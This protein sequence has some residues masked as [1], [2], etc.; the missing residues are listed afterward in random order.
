MAYNSSKG[1][2]DVQHI[3]ASSEIFSRSALTSEG[4]LN[5]SGSTALGDNKADVI[6]I[7]GQLTGSQGAYFADRVGVGVATPD[8]ALEVA[9]NV[10]LSTE[11]TTPSTPAAADGGV[12]YVK[13][14]GNLYWLSD[15][16][17]EV[18]LSSG[19]GISFNGSTANGVV[20]YGGATQADVEANM[21]FNGSQL[22]VTG[23]MSASSAVK[24]SNIVAGG[25][26]VISEGRLIQNVLGATIGGPITTT[27]ALSGSSGFHS[28]G[29]IT[30]EGTL[31]ATGSVVASQFDVGATNVISS[32]RLIQNVLGATIGGPLTATG[33]MSGSS[34]LEA[35]GATILGST[36]NV[37]G[38]VTLA[39]P[40][41]GSIAGPG[42]YLG[43]TPTGVVVLAEASG[44]GI[45]FN[46]STAN[47]V[48]TY[49]GATQADVEANLT[50]DG[51][52]LTATNSSNTAI[53]AITIDRN[54]TGT[55][56]IGNYTTDPQ[57]LLVDYD[58]T[59]IV[60]SGQTAIH[61]AISI[62]YNQDSPTM[63][64][65]IE[66]TG[67]DIRMTGGTS[68]TQ[69]MKGLAMTLA[70]AST[71]TGIDITAPNDST[72]FIA[73]SSDALLDQFKIS[74][75][76]GGATTLSTN[77]ADATAAHLTFSVD[78][79]IVL[80]PAGSNVTVDG[81]LSG[82]G[83]LEMVGATVL[84][85]TLAVSGTVSVAAKIEHAG[86]TDTYIDFTDDDINFQ[87][88]GVNFLDLTQDTQ[89]E[90][91][92]NEAG[93]DIDFRVET[94][95]ESHML[96]IE[97][98]SNRM[99]IG[100]NTG[101]PGATLEVKNNATAGAF[102]VP[103][104]RLNSNDT[105]QQCLDINAANID[106][107]V[108]DI[109]A[110]AVT[111]AKVLNIGADG[112]TTGNAFRVDDNSA[113]TGTRNT[114]L[115]I[116]NN[117]AAIAATALAVQSD[118]GVTGVKI[119]KNYS[120]TAEASV[121]GLDIDFDKTAATTSDN[122]MYGIQLDMD[123]TTAT[124]GTNYMYGLHVTPTLTHA[125]D[126]GSSFV[127]GAWINAQGGTNGTGYVQGARIEAGG[128]DLNFGLQLDVEDGGVDLRIES[129][130][131]NGDYFQ[132]QTTTHGA[133][134]ITTVD[135]NATA[136]D[137]TFNVD[138]DITLDPV[139][140]TVV[141]D[142]VLSGSSALKGSN[143][144]AGGAN[145]ISDGRLIQ[146]VLGATIGG[147]LTT[148]GDLSGSGL[149]TIVGGIVN[150]GN[151]DVS[152][153]A[154]L[155]NAASD[156]T[157]ATGRLTGSQGAYFAGRVGI[158]QNAPAY[159]LDL[160]GSLHLNGNLG[161]PIAPLA[162]EG[163]VLF[164][165]GSGTL[166]WAS[167]EQMSRDISNQVFHKPQGCS[168]SWVDVD[169]VQFTPTGLDGNGR[170]SL[171][172]DTTKHMMEYT[173]TGSIEADIT[174]SGFNGLDTGTEAANTGYYIYIICKDD[175][176]LP[177][178]LFSTNNINPTMPSGYTYRSQPIWFVS[179]DGSAEIRGFNQRGCDGTFYYDNFQNAIDNGQQLQSSGWAA[180]DMSE[181]VPSASDAL[182]LMRIS[183]DVSAGTT[184][185]RLTTDNGTAPAS[186]IGTYFVGRLSSNGDV[187]TTTWFDWALS[188]A[189]SGL[190]YCWVN[191]P[192]SADQGLRIDVG[193]FK[194]W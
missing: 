61:D 133:T 40:A 5:I 49:G 152:G 89:N 79:N 24:G 125:A 174:D 158:S 168:F 108:V 20:T 60:A 181:F 180:V 64:G 137:L 103:L 86:D 41:S 54:Y 8:S 15:D 153:S 132:I 43:V 130:A 48:V 117:A 104:L 116:Q 139:G 55:T 78:G 185:C 129:S 21:T 124:N 45:S 23:I 28:A 172:K 88:G 162:T 22:S 30:A 29:N 166:Y 53:P 47:G 83:T 186:G 183:G 145:V 68:G 18:S 147:P 136:A 76:A 37:S 42:S 169:T 91:T 93:A 62:N 114:A 191:D 74:V 95:D 135:D 16:V 98:S 101:S 9:G 170:V 4:N 131:D 87:A 46:G 160:S 96:F 109:L 178:M 100:D 1:T 175:G 140:G 176:L 163:G 38:A 77:D 151:L 102:G 71:I 189:A 177:G 39:G 107:N 155:G 115:I 110:N 7:T 27:G 164:G 36:L 192:G 14:D 182:L 190:Y 173:L 19:P 97:G 156:V 171:Y 193:G 111:T 120:D 122:T 75:G 34:I 10:H 184:T 146:N 82:S 81:N 33:T 119:D 121:V 17:A 90:V 141:V 112:L 179:Q 85:N 92:F 31:E 26:N 94:A 57:G 126:A 44:G 50:F 52:T 2:F 70:G 113:D 56:S 11:T 51:N 167:T 149:A 127:Y 188:N 165:S 12:M 150:E 106:A 148:T 72:H 25:A 13:A 194:M 66:A 187:A 58:V 144:V 59:G 157:T 123:N 134:T 142:G 69:S 99:S 6:T 32:G 84:G 128:G 63:V 143:I 161:A 35:V 118:G 159:E 65:T 73:R 138:G 67:A 154:T 105:D 80:D 3:S